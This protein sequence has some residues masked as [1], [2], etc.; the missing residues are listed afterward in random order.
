MSCD[1]AADLDGAVTIAALQVGLPQR[2]HKEP[3]DRRG[4]AAGAQPRFCMPVGFWDAGRSRIGLC[5][6]RFRDMACL[7]ARASAVPP[8]SNTRINRPATMQA[9]QRPEE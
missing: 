7:A 5:G 8:S 9:G 4:Y 3:L 2:G 1:R 6:W